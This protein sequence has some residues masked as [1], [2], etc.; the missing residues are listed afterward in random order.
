MRDLTINSIS[1]GALGLKLS[2]ID[3]PF[4]VGETKSYAQI[5]DDYS[6]KNDSGFLYREKSRPVDILLGG[7]YGSLILAETALYR[8]VGILIQPG[9]KSFVYYDL[10][11][12]I[13]YNIEFSGIMNRGIDARISKRGKYLEVSLKILAS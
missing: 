9:S 6:S 12:E 3:G 7:K 1:V 8:L 11:D 2:R 13:N 4:S 5:K 10:A